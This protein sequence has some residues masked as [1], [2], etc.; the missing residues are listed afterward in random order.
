MITRALIALAA[1]TGFLYA[2]APD[3]DAAPPACRVATHRAIAPDT[4]EEQPAGITYSTRYR[5]GAEID[6]RLSADGTPWAIH[7]SGVGRIS[8]GAVKRQVIDMTDAELAAVPLIHGG[9]PHTIAALAA[10][11]AGAG[12]RLMIELKPVPAGATVRWASAPKGV[13]TGLDRLSTAITDAG[14]NDRVWWTSS[15]PDVWGNVTADPRFTGRLAG[16]PWVWDPAQPATLSGLG[17][18]YL[19]PGD[20][21]SATVQAVKAA[22][23]VPLRHA[24]TTSETKR[25]YAAGVRLFISHHPGV[26]ANAC[27]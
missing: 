9:H 11:A 27:G 19:A 23:V 25:A 7:D 8:G 20:V 18:A 22:G 4:D 10:A 26:T 16:R 5:W 15:R 3:A 13:A 1:I 24:N 14:M 12:A 21:S 6:A 2:A 17:V